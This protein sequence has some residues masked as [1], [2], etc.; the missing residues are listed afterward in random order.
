MNLRNKIIFICVYFLN[1]LLS[2]A[3]C[4]QKQ[5]GEKDKVKD[6]SFTAY[7]LAAKSGVGL[8][9]L[10]PAYYFTYA[11]GGAFRKVKTKAFEDPQILS[12]IINIPILTGAS[13][14]A[15]Q[16][17]E[18]FLRAVRFNLLGYDSDELFA[19]RNRTGNIFF[20]ERV[21][22][23]IKKDFS[24]LDSLYAIQVRAGNIIIVDSDTMFPL[25]LMEYMSGD[26]YDL[27][28]QNYYAAVYY[29]AAAY[30]WLFY[31]LDNL[32]LK[33]TLEKKDLNLLS[34]FA[35][36]RY[37]LSNEIHEYLLQSNNSLLHIALYKKS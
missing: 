33:Q 20:N 9:T 15:D 36:S 30:P 1:A 12:L 21:L 3:L 6:V 26:G 32:A 37:S 4:G 25:M 7:E 16:S 10:L 27:E 28:L 5:G 11:A 13:I 17:K 31:K 19:N 35:S 34:Q 18:Y 8:D 24:G 14:T 29:W 23:F 2:N 22:N